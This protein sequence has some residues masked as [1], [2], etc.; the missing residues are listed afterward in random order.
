M[1]SKVGITPL[2]GDC[3]KSH[4]QASVFD[5]PNHGMLVFRCQLLTPLLEKTETMQWYFA[6]ADDDEEVAVLLTYFFHSFMIIASYLQNTPIFKM[7][8]CPEKVIP[9]L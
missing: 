8:L 2:I 7:N 6:Q 9:Q 3:S 1:E 5:N 4:L